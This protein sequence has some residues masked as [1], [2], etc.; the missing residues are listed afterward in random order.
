[1]MDSF[2]DHGLRRPLEAKNLFMLVRVLPVLFT[3]LFSSQIKFDPDSS[4]DLI[5]VAQIG[6]EWYKLD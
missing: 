3:A 2:P 6:L 4:C 5:R 1:M